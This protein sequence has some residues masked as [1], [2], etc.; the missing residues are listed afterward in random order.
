MNTKL[1][2]FIFVA[3]ACFFSCGKVRAEQPLQ[4]FEG[5]RVVLLGD[6]LIEREQEFGFL[7]TRLYTRFAGRKFIVRN[8]GWSADGPAGDSRA[9]FD[10]AQPEKGFEQ[11]KAQIVAIKPTVVFIGYGMANSF[12]GEEGLPKFK[13]DLAKL[14]DMIQGVTTDKNVRFVLLSPLRHEKLPAPLPDPSEHNARLAIYSTAIAEVAK[15]RGFPFIS[16]FDWMEKASKPPLTDNGIHL[17]ARGYSLLAETIEKNLGWKPLRLS[18]KKAEA[19]RHLVVAKNKLFFNRWRPQN[20]TYLFGFRKYEQGQNAKEIPMFDPFVAAEEAKIFQLASAS[21]KNANTESVEEPDKPRKEISRKL[22]PI[23]DSY[24]E[25]KITPLP[26]FEVAPGFEVSLYAEN[27]MLAKPIQMNF[28]PQGRLW[29]ASSAIYPQI[30]PGQEAD[31]TIL[32]VE[33]TNGDGKADKSTV[34]ADGLMIPTGVAPGDGGVYVA[35]GTQL[36][37]FKDTDGDGKADEKRIVLSGFGTEDTHHI[38][39][40]L[41]W[42]RDGELYF[43]QSIYIHS[44][45]ETP[46]GVVRLNSGGIFHLRPPTMDLSIFLRGFCNPWGHDFDEFGQSFVTD[47]AGGQGI[48]F[49]IEGATYFTYATLRRELRGISPGSYPKF[50]GLEIVASKQFPDDWQGN[51]ITADFRAH[52]VVRFALEEQGGGFVTKEMPDL[53]RTTNV[54]F[55]PIDMKFGPDGALYIAD[56]SN[57][58]IQHG[59]VDFRD[60]RRDH[61]HGRIW[62]V[63]AKN[64]PSF[65]RPKLIRASNTEL[66]NELLSPNAFNS[67]QSRRVLT[68]RGAKIEKDLAKWAKA[69]STEKGILQAL[70]MYQAINVLDLRALEAA[71]S[72]SDGRIRAAAVR[73]LAA[74]QDRLPSSPQV[75]ARLVTDSH[76]RV[77]IEAVRAL[78][79]IPTANSAELV[80]GVLNKPMDPFLDYA[81]WLS[82]NDLAKPWVDAIQ[83]GEWKIDGREKQL[84]FGLQ[85]IEPEMA[86]AVLSQLLKNKPLV[87]DG[88]GAWIELIGRSGGSKELQTLYDQVLQN[89]F[90]EPASV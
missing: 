10:F 81:V 74:W 60:P 65:K 28:D 70:W 64:S 78:A 90:A 48:N 72:A 18:E 84:E 54:T 51:V 53:L 43:D 40:T 38:L 25:K 77:R 29:I 34:F 59:E 63:A 21:G 67:E 17:N 26:D 24:V 49:G 76:P 44:H 3:V 8:L 45:I 4:I 41:R 39:H 47:G 32:V 57:P 56:W 80:L 42:G 79:R 14:I 23:S 73:V 30:E 50:C 7:E 46:N 52:R 20:E 13:A 58:I 12:A 55:R 88:S 15:E 1:S 37:H 35:Q 22:G 85:A 36:L 89:G 66:L 82:I 87:R 5:D 19:I 86:S 61:E 83:S 2:Q 62:R 9:R 31:D 68:E 6:T 75:L 69:Q 71:L 33:D 16:L 11:I 27:P